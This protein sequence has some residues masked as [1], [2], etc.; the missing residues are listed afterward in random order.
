MTRLSPSTTT[1][2]PDTPR[3]LTRALMICCACPSASRVGAEPSGVRAVSVTRVPPCRSMPSFGLGLLVPGEKHQQ[4][5]ADQQDQEH[6]QVAVRGAPAPKTMPRSLYLLENGQV[7][8]PAIGSPRTRERVRVRPEG[9]CSV[10]AGRGWARCHPRHFRWCRTFGALRDLGGLVASRIRRRSVVVSS[11]SGSDPVADGQLHP[12]GHH[13]G[14]DLE[15]D[16]V[17]GDARR[18]WPADRTWCAPDRRCAAIRAGRW[19]PA[20]RVFWRRDA[21]YMNPPR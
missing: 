8:L 7:P 15:V 19:W 16:G 4:V 17:V 2:E 14:G 1:S 13:A 3:P 9:Q 20:S 21:R 12:G 11:S 18:W 10:T 5:D 6:R